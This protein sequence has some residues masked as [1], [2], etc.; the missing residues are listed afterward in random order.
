[1]S[2]P[3][4]SPDGRTLAFI[5]SS[6]TYYGLGQIYVKVLPDG[7]PVQ[8]TN[9]SLKK[10]SPSFSPDGTR[11]AYT[12]VD[13]QWNWDTWIVPAQGGEPELLRKNATSLT[14]TGQGQMLFSEKRSNGGWES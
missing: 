9:D 12:M 2:Q 10:M 11:I 7:K 3:A 14:W 13:G 4:L 1:V 5:R 6:S 8:L